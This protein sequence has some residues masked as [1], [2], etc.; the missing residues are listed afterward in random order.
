MLL[1]SLLHFCFCLYIIYT[2]LLFCIVL[3]IVI[4]LPS[5]AIAIVSL[6]FN[7]KSDSYRL[8]ERKTASSITIVIFG[9]ALTIAITIKKR[10]KELKQRKSNREKL[11]IVTFFAQLDLPAA[12]RPTIII[13]SHSPRVLIPGL[14]RTRFS[15]ASLPI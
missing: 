6:F 1:T 5:V 12:G 14:P 8:Y 9:R 2:L 11:K 15:G 3:R 13:N 7:L 10:S 4:A